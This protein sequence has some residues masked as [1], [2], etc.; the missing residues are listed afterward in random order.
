MVRMGK[1]APRSPT[2]SKRCRPDQGIQGSPTELTD[3]G[4]QRAHLPRGEQAGQ[5]SPMDGVQRRVLEDQHPGGDLDV[6]FDE[7]EHRTARRTERLAIEEAALNVLESTESVEVVGLVV[8]DGSLVVQAPVHGIGVGVDLRVIRVVGEVGR[9][10]CHVISRCLPGR[11]RTLCELVVARLADRLYLWTKRRTRQERLVP[12][13]QFQ[14]HRRVR[15]PEPAGCGPSRG[16]PRMRNA[17]PDHAALR[18]DQR[19]F[20]TCRPSRAMA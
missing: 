16:R 4:F 12:L 2:K 10:V 11:S 5:D 20:W 8:V 17:T 19:L 7:L 14:L 3:L 15:T 6:G 13:E 1:S 9:R 18:G